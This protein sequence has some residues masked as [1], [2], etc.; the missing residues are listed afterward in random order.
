MVVHDGRSNSD[1]FFSLPSQ[2]SWSDI[3]T[4]RSE[5]EFYSCFVCQNA[6]MTGS[7]W[8]PM[9]VLFLTTVLRNQV[10]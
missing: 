9:M 4:P 7:S 8:G 5:I 3:C 10:L 1:I 6:E 2:L